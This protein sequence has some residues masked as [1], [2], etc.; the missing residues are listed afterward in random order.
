MISVCVLMSAYNGELFIE[1]QLQSLLCQEGVSVS[2]LVRDDGSTDRTPEILDR[3]QR[4]GLLRWYGGQN[5]GWAM[6][7]IHLLCHAPEADYYAFCDHDDIWLPTKLLEAVDMLGR[8]DGERRLYCSNLRYYRDGRDEGLVVAAP[9]HH[10]IH[11]AMVRNIATGCT[12]VFSRALQQAIC[13][14]P[15]KAVFAHDYW[16]YQ[17]A[18]ATGG[19]VYDMRSFILYRQH[20][21]NQIGQKRSWLEVWSRRLKVLGRLSHQHDRELLARELLACHGSEMNG[22]RRMAVERMAHYRESLS[23]RLSLFFDRRYTMGR[24]SNDCWLR[25]RILLGKV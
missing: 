24:L 13:Q 21:H 15:P 4:D 14:H 23:A 12:I 16:V 19:V 9:P 20:A 7:F 3:W 1:E 5:L 10:D 6:S 18:E 2:I 11:T 25:L 22:E 8:M 17:V